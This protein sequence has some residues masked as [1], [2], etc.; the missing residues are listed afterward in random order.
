MSETQKK[1]NR[2]LLT[3]INFGA[4]IVVIVLLFYTFKQLN[5][6][7]FLIGVLSV[8]LMVVTTC[9]EYYFCRIIFKYPRFV[10]LRKI[11]ISLSLMYIGLIMLI[12]TISIS[13]SWNFKFICTVICQILYSLITFY[14]IYYMKK[15]KPLSIYETRTADN[16]LFRIHYH[17]NHD[18]TSAVYSPDIQDEG[19]IYIPPDLYN[20]NDNQS[21]V[22]YSMQEV[23]DPI[24]SDIE[25]A[26]SSPPMSESGRNL[27]NGMQYRISSRRA[28]SSPTICEMPYSLE[29][30]ET[31]KRKSSFY[32]DYGLPSNSDFNIND[33]S[34]S[35]YAIYLDGIS[36]TGAISEYEVYYGQSEMLDSQQPM[37]NPYANVCAETI[38]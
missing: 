31:Y 6:K 25:L 17:H 24:S 20:N 21:T 16:N 14:A 15:V 18:Q 27:T 9:L 34:K 8:L 11:I 2:P 1:I 5:Y 12:I 37:C 10:K 35:C 19:N 29:N 7:F 33:V 3:S 26:V 23:A 32:D 22:N 36:T 28:A 30:K 38:I 13:N 4:T